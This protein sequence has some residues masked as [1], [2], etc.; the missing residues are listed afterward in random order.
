[1][2][3][4]ISEWAEKSIPNLFIFWGGVIIVFGGAMILFQEIFS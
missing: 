3:N 2:F 1:M 4:R